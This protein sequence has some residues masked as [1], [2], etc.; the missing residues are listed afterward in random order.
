MPIG[1]FPKPSPNR[2]IQAYQ[3]L[4]NKSP[5]TA[6]NRLTPSAAQ[7]YLGTYIGAEAADANLAIVQL[8][9]GAI[10]HFVPKIAGLTLVPGDTVKLEKSGAT[11]L[12]VA[13]KMIGN[14][15]LASGAISNVTPPGPPTGYASPSDTDTT[16]N[17]TWS[18][19]VDHFGSGLS[20][21]IFVN[22]AFRQSTAVGALSATITG[23]KANT[24]YNSYVVAQD[25]AGNNSV[26]SNTINNTTDPAP[27]PPGGS[28]VT[29][30][31]KATVLRSYNYNGHNE[32]DM[33]H[34][35]QAYQGNPQDGTSYNQFGLI[36]F[37]WAQI[38]SDTSGKDMVNAK[39]SLTY[40]HFYFNSGG[41]AI[42]GT[43]D[44]VSPP[45]TQSDSHAD[46]DL[47]RVNADAGRRFTL[48]MGVTQA[49]NFQSGHAKGIQVGPQPSDIPGGTCYGYTYG[50][51]SQVPV[52]TLSWNA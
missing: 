36:I 25:G 23:L 41:K 42:I 21:N 9:G 20:Y 31:Y 13:G 18:A 28:L 19:G 45:S 50:L 26:P 6:V 22:G 43:H 37:N 40:A 39:I 34:D 47:F 32:R 11:P 27:D 29:K 48:T 52:L 33:W 1:Q 7:H 30:T 12:H 5:R 4:A 17:V 24:N 49:N 51:G 15:T 16:M 14:F 35:G 2:L 46:K 8:A 3:Q 44:Y 38:D 10:V